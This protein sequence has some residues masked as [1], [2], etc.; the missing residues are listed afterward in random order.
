MKI[1]I[2]RYSKIGI[3]F[4]DVIFDGNTLITVGVSYA[5]VLHDVPPFGSN[6][7]LLQMFNGN[8][9]MIKLMKISCYHLGEVC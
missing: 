5:G 4:C 8:H 1:T 6:T 3:I 7:T 9:D 2:N